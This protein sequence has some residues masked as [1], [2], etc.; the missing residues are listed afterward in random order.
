M[1]AENTVKYEGYSLFS[2]DES[3]PS[4]QT[5]EVFAC[6]TPARVNKHFSTFS[7]EFIWHLLALE[8]NLYLEVVSPILI[9]RVKPSIVLPLR[10]PRGLRNN[11]VGNLQRWLC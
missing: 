1:Y 3:M 6:E 10:S 7:S 9:V 2:V 4:V 5:L 8:T 11:S